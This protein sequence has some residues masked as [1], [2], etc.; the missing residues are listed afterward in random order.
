MV[1]DGCKKYM[2]KTCGDVLDNLK[3]DCYQ[4]FLI[5]HLLKPDSVS[6]SH[7]SSVKPRS[8]ADEEL[9]SPVL[10]E[11]C[12]PVLKRYA[13]EGRE[14]DYTRSHHVG[15]AGH[16][17]LT[18]G[19]PRT[20]ASKSLALSPGWSAVARSRLT[21]TST[22]WV[23]RQGFTM[24]AR[25][26]SKLLTS[27][28]PPTSA[29]QSA[30]ITG[31]SQRARPRGNCVNLTE[32][33]SLYEEQLGRLYC[34]VEFSK[35]IVCVPSYLELYPLTMTDTVLP[36]QSTQVNLTPRSSVT[37]VDMQQ[38]LVASGW[39]RTQQRRLPAE[40]RWPARGNENPL[41][42]HSWG[43]TV[44]IRLISNSWPQVIHTP[45]PPKV[46]GLQAAG[47]EQKL[48]DVQWSDWKM[49]KTSK[50]QSTKAKIDKWDYIKLKSFTA[51]EKSEETTYRMGEHIWKLMI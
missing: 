22:S 18:S 40:T 44:L 38:G 41:D 20:L 33:L 37:A 32:A 46:L 47:E 42:P 24:L 9:R 27:G 26:V 4:K 19:D 35:E 17:L 5:I 30:G 8:L 48:E 13:K 15:Q 12:I 21:V 11:D 2:R 34:P 29:S 36:D 14:F 6:S 43:F 10:I 16:E 39:D 28:D 7:S 23:Q 51:K 25:L 49:E 3:G 1:I 50:A 31:V 45:P